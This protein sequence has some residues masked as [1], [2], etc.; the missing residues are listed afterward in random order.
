MALVSIPIAMLHLI[1]MYYFSYNLGI[2]AGTQEGAGLC[3]SSF[4]HFCLCSSTQ[5]IKVQP[6]LH[7]RFSCLSSAPLRFD[8]GLLLIFCTL[9]VFRQPAPQ[10]F[11]ALPRLL[12]T[13]CH[14]NLP[15]LM[16]SRYEPVTLHHNSLPALVLGI[17]I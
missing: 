5:S 15:F 6:R 17:T 12:Y 4:L 14:Q 8:S 16:S 3:A 7:Q 10:V 1:D 9:L 11:I 13:I 2:K